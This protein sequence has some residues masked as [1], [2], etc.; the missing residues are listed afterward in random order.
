MSIEIDI[1]P[2]KNYASITYS[3]GDISGDCVTSPN[4]KYYLLVDTFYRNAG[5]D[6]ESVVVFTRDEVIYKKAIPGEG[7]I[8]DRQCRIFDDGSCVF[9]VDEETLYCLGPD[10]KQR[11]KRK[12]GVDA[13]HVEVYDDM[14]YAVGY[15]DDG[16][17]YLW[18][19]DYAD[20]K[21][22][23]AKIGNEALG[24]EP[25][26]YDEDGDPEYYDDW[27]VDVVRVGPHMVVIGADAMTCQA[28][29]FRLAT[30]APTNDERRA[31]IAA[32]EA[33][34]IAEAEAR[35]QRAAERAAY[36]A[37]KAEGAKK[38]TKRGFSISA[39]IE[40]FRR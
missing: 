28:F 29:D 19:C 12:I 6:V 22:K 14:A 21:C 24:T 10:G 25:C 37:R 23:T 34:L 31:A 30:V 1:D 13:E 33:R 35:A 38:K 18:V 20:F 17:Y 39:L 40:R 32:R 36:E 15:G 11:A 26:G 9:V 7:C 2:R 8:E 4:G 16:D 5:D 3:N 27:E